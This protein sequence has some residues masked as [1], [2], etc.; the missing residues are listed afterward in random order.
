MKQGTLKVFATWLVFC[1]GAVGMSLGLL[2]GS[3]LRE[4]DSGTY[5]V[6][7]GY[8]TMKF[9]NWLSNVKDI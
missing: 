8:L 6:V 9:S 4:Y 1:I 2:E 3:L 7:T 5:H